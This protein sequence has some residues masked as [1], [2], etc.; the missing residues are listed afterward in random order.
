MMFSGVKKVPLE[1][2]ASTAHITSSD[3]NE[4]NRRKIA[5]TLFDIEMAI[6]SVH[7]NDK[8]SSTKKNVAR[9]CSGTNPFMSKPFLDKGGALCY[10]ALRHIG[11]DLLNGKHAEP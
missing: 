4:P 9:Y 6:S 2:T 8:S 3:I 1:A 10:N 5:R 7:P 11:K